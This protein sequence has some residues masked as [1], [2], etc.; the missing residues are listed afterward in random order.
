[1][2]NTQI[3]RGMTTVSF[4]ADDMIAARAWYSELLGMDA[5]FQRP[6]AENPGYIEFRIG[7]YQHELG[8]IDRKYAPKGSAGVPGGAILFWHVDNLEEA[9]ERIKSMGAKEYEPQTVRG[10]GFV[11]ASV[12]DPFGNVLGLMYNKHYL[13]TLDAM[14]KA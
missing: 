10:E 1:M 4:Y 9:L 8:I 11:T 2:A 5:Y 14:K 12:V 6:D 7:D 3:L 13:E